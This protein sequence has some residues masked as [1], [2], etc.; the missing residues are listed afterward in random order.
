MKFSLLAQVDELSTFQRAVREQFAK[1]GT[2][3]D[4]LIL[5]GS[6]IAFV[7]FCRVLWRLQQRITGGVDRNDPRKLFTQIV[8]RL[9]LTPPERRC[10]YSVARTADLDHPTAILLSPLLFDEAST[11]WRKRRAVSVSTRD[12][13]ERVIAGLRRNLFPS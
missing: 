12:R 7:V 13:E 9:Q 3:Q 1:H 4:F 6:L 2:L 5:W 11:N 10:L 8:K